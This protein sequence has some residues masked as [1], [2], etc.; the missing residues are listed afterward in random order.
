[1]SQVS[2]AQDTLFLSFVQSLSELPF[3]LCALIVVQSRSL[4]VSSQACSLL[5]P[6]RRDGMANRLPSTLDFGCLLAVR[7]LSP[8]LA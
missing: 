6:E 4:L 5:P 2:P 3:S 8:C 1:M 7:F